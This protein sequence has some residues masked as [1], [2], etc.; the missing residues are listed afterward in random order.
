MW[1]KLYIRWS[2]SAKNFSSVPHL[3]KESNYVKSMELMVE[4][5]DVIMQNGNWK[6]YM[7]IVEMQ[8]GLKTHIF[9]HVKNDEFYA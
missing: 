7:C 6:Y 8:I 2:S 9:F 1:T 3:L 4:N 5:E